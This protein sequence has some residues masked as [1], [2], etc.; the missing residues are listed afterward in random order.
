LPR[1]KRLLDP[2]IKKIC[3]RIYE[4][5]PGR[6]RQLIN[7]VKRQQKYEYTDPMI[8]DALRAFEPYK[9]SVI[10][11]WPYLD[12]VLDKIYTKAKQGEAGQYKSMTK[13]ELTKVGAILRNIMEAS[14][15]HSGLLEGLGFKRVK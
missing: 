2:T 5:D 1:I 13:A 12:K 10:I 7:W 15:P 14:D 11:W 3:S 6:Y 4:S 8:A 9:D